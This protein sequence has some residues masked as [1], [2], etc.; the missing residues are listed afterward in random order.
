M[1]D[2]SR[3]PFFLPSPPPS[4]EGGGVAV[5][6]GNPLGVAPRN[7]VG[8]RFAFARMQVH[9]A[10]I[11]ANA[12]AGVVRILLGTQ[13]VQYPPRYLA[14]IV[15]FNEQAFFEAHEVWEDV[16]IEKSGLERKFYQGLIQA[17]VSLCHFGNGNF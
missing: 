2:F 6:S 10:R 4:G 13:R 15:L 5:P 16:W 17:A 7:K 14:G 3:R 9:C 11:L 12:A 8:H 1:E